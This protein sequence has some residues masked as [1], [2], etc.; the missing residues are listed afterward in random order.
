MSETENRQQQRSDN[1][2]SIQLKGQA[3]LES[4][5]F[6]LLVFNMNKNKNKNTNNANQSR[7]AY[8][9]S[10][11]NSISSVPFIVQISLTSV[12]VRRRSFLSSPPP[13]FCSALDTPR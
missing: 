9:Y 11:V 3:T 10:P 2:A 7:Q 13:F 1:T 4:V 5:M 6:Q 8:A 12:S